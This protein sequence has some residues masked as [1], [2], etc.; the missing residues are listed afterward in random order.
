[1]SS[2][3]V[4]KRKTPK[5]GLRCRRKA[6]SSDDED[7]RTAD[8]SLSNNQISNATPN[9]DEDDLGVDLKKLEELRELRGLK[10]KQSRGLSAEQLLNAGSG[11]GRSRGMTAPRKT[12]G[13][14]TA[15]ALA[16]DL[17]LRKT[18]SVETNRRDEDADMLKFIEEELAKRKG[19]VTSGDESSGIKITEN[20][21]DLVFNV[22]PEHLLKSNEKKTEEMLSNQMLSGIPEV[23]LGVHERIRNIEAT[24]MAKQKLI[25]KGSNF[26][27][28]LPN[29][30]QESSA[31]SATYMQHNKFNL[32]DMN[33]MR[34][35]G[36]KKARVDQPPMVKVI[37]EAVVVI[38]DEPKES[39]FKVKP[40]GGHHML[41]FPGREKPTD[42]Y[43]Y[44]KFK[45][46][47]RK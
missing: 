25:K 4:F 26:D 33:A 45:K 30:L 44:E 12:V 39:L 2:E 28:N 27:L 11:N 29:R 37:K 22:L 23:D 24:E 42:D 36:A 41:K 9:E 31:T 40:T 46:S 13:L 5:A 8:Q 3:I 15:D 10:H 19:K 1:M 21:N 47:F 14:T 17:D 43:H 18:F 35:P 6:N 20:L 7:S 32:G 34:P 16:S 38:G